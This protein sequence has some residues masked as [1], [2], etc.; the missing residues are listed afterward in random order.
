MAKKWK[1]FEQ[2]TY[3]LQKQ[4]ADDSEVLLD[5]KIKG[6]ESETDRQID[7][8]VKKKIGQYD[9]LVVIECKDYK[10]PVDVSTVE[11][12]V[13]KLRD[14]RANKGAIISGKG[15]SKAATS[16]AA[17]HG[18]ETFRYVDTQSKDWK[19][20]MAINAAA[21]VVV[22]TRYQFQVSDFVELPGDFVQTVPDLEIYSP[23]DSMPIGKVRDILFSKWNENKVPE[24]EGLQE[25]VLVERG[26]IGH[27][28]GS[29]YRATIKAVIEV[30]RKFYFGPL[31]VDLIGLHNQQTGGVVTRSFTTEPIEIEKLFTGQLEGWR[32]VPR[33]DDLAI[34]PLMTFRSKSKI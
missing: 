11:A 28:R 17:K 5:Q 18:I 20:Y 24:E 1:K 15:F 27:Q 26:L 34:S 30:E 6:F 16:L 33:R 19:A 32:Q 14:V 9:I 7:I 8:L 4:L 3:D 23:D 21:E 10:R 22:M 2:L 31:P 12:F 29:L 25:I 13:T